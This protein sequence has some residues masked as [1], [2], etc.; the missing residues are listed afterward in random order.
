FPN[1]KSIVPAAGSYPISVTFKDKDELL[2]ALKRVQPFC[3]KKQPA[4]NFEYDGDTTVN[5]LAVKEEMLAT[6][7][8][9]T[10]MSIDSILVEGVGGTAKIK[11]DIKRIQPFFE[12]AIFPVTLWLKKGSP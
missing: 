6:G 5:L 12:R 10:D 7:N 3:D 8:V 2:A 9:Y 4:V 1:Y 11:L